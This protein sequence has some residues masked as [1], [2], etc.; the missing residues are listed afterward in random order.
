MVEKNPS[1]MKLT[2]TDSDV[3]VAPYG[4]WKSPITSEMIVS[5]SIQLGQV[6][7]DND[8]IYWVEMRPAEAGRNVI[9]RRSAAGGTEDITPPRFN[10]RTRVH[11]YGGGSY[12][13]DEET[14]YF[15]NFN[16]QRLYCQSQSGL[17]AAI[18]PEG[19][20]CY[21]DSVKD[22][23]RNR[24][25]CVREDR[26]E[27]V[28]A[29]VNTIVTLGLEEEDLGQVLIGGNDFYSSPR[30]S[31]DGSKLAWLTWNHP[32]MPWDGTELWVGDVKNDGSIG[33]RNKV[34]GGD[35]ESIFQPEW[36]PEGVLYFVSDRSGWWNLYRLN[37]GAIEH[38]VKK[39]AE[40]GL[41]QWL[42]GMS[43][44]AFESA[45][46]LVCTYLES[47]AWQLATLNTQSLEF[48]AIRTPFTDIDEV[49]ATNG[50]AIFK[51][52]SSSRPI[53]LVQF[54]LNN[55]CLETIRPTAEVDLPAHYFCDPEPIE[56]PTENGL[57]AHGYY[58]PPQN[59]NFAAPAGELP[60]LIVKSHGGPTAA[61]STS[62]DL[63]TQFWTSRGFALLD[64]NYGGST[65]YGRNY[66]ERLNGNWG[67]TDVDDCVNG[68][69]YL[70][71]QGL[72]DGNR[73]AIV[74]GSA[75]GYTTLAALTFRDFFHAGAS[76]YGVSDLEALARDIHKFESR[77]LD[78]LI[79][80]YPQHKD[81]YVKRS[82]IHST[83]QLSCP[84][85]VFQGLEDKVVP[86]NQAEMMVE[87]ARNKGIPVAYL[88]FEGEQ[89]G[90]RQAKNIRRALEA[91]LYFYSKVFGFDLVDAI[92]PVPIE[93][94][95]AH[96][97]G[98]T[99]IPNSMRKLGEL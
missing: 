65:G 59:P 96:P 64:V 71:K 33:E 11:E 38:L 93:N 41:P 36:S 95:A 91:E 74:G 89:H 2:K 52:G 62:L 77:Y 39:S 15:S 13:V 73:L 8:D 50:F 56:F 85:I 67:I 76:Y 42:F 53:S 44:Y 78:R 83:H 58:Y 82:P 22:R 30:L 23:R 86:P 97:T 88:L 19:P 61:T 7:L 16:D 69:S 32:N 37:E 25:I 60:P 68:A 87:A 79:G 99:H 40:F 49:R 70:V 17:P 54:D 31:P 27:S 20:F 10:A 57:T 5:E 14:I 55:N 84:I 66:R 26:R 9:V 75:G 72:V 21:A 47:G 90:F 29:A 28:Q 94:L 43:T 18:T 12:L 1:G 81:T 51:G 6:C 4:S 98:K 46:R 35:A 48:R 45:S 80:P 92:E 34:A 3:Q 24:L 63:K